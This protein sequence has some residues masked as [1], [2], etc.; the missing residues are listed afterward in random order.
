[1]KKKIIIATIILVA[2]LLACLFIYQNK[3]NDKY[4]LIELTG[5]ELLQ[6][7]IDDEEA[8][9]T[10]ALYNERDVQ[11]EDFY[12]D[13]EQVVTQ[14]HQDIY[15]V[16]TSHVTF[17]FEEIINTLTG[18][19]T[20]I[21][22]YYVIQDGKVLLSNTYSNFNTMYKELN[23][24]KYDTKVEKMSKEEKLEYIDKAHEAYFEGDIAS[25]HNYLSNAWDIKEAKDEWNNH[26]Y[27]Q[28]IG[29]WEQFEVQEDGKTTRYINFFFTT[30][31]SQ[32]YTMDTVTEI[33]GFTAPSFDLYEAHDIQI[34]DNYI[35]IKNKKND[36]YEK[37]YE[38]ITISKYAFQI[39]DGKT[40]Y[41]FQ[42]GY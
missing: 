16:N 34:K 41:K 26:P 39:T 6:V 19:T 10:F 36:K 29:N 3:D 31:A 25:A 1:M 18:S 20:D 14:A 33:E 28:I 11:A 21:L 42:Y 15:Y 37:K 8:S 22:S 30:F 24:K 27:Y 5:Q 38:R 35:Y 17:E 4:Q 2:F 7:F 13:L 32:M 12:N 23:G 40:T 9:I